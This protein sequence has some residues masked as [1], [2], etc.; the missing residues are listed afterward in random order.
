MQNI[1]IIGAGLSSSSLIQYLLERSDQYQWKITLGDLSLALAQQKIGT[2][3]NGKAIRFNITDQQQRADEI[4]KADIVISMLPARMHILVAKD[5]LY[6]QKHLLTPSYITPE[7]KDLHK[8]AESKDLCFINELG[9]DPGIDH[10]SAMKIISEIKNKGGI[11]HSFQSY[12]GGLIANESDTNPW[13]YKFTWN[14]R[15]VVLAG[16]GIAKY[17][18]D[19]R[20][21]YLPYQHL[22]AHP[23]QILIR[24][25]GKFEAYANRD[26]LKYQQLYG[27]NDISTLIRGTIRKA[28][29]C[30]AWHILVQM[31]CTDDSYIMKDSHLLTNKEY[32]S[33]FLPKQQD[34]KEYIQEQFHLDDHSP[35]LHQLQWLGLFGNSKMKVKN[36]SPAMILQKILEEKWKMEADDRDLIVMQNLLEYEIEGEKRKLTSSMIYEGTDKQNTAMAYT[37]GTPLAIAAKL[38]ACNQIQTR[39]VFI[40]IIAELYEPIYQELHE[41]GIQFHEEDSK[42]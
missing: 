13:H 34:P 28:G 9:V 35:F 1:L 32:I 16:Q 2:H 42:L 3:P 12:C 27:L 8:E 7:M 30:Q 14:P 23:K 10:I 39:G 40:P 21:K 5:C 6:F 17:K 31:G 38:L 24:G 37:V 4:S 29:Y 15:N 26:S 11:I 41:L 19:K 36:A 18:E 33:A 20:F 25:K 22:F